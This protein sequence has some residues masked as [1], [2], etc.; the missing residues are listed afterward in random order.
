VGHSPDVVKQQRGAIAAALK[1]HLDQ[2]ATG[3]RNTAEA[4][5]V[6]AEDETNLCQEARDDLRR[7]ARRLEKVADD[8][9]GIGSDAIAI[10]SPE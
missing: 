6:Q 8:I 3:M 1:N 5:A 10:R 7:A 2:V 9:E 4:L